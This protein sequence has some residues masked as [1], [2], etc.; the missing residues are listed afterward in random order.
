MT[1]RL[2][3]AFV[4]LGLTACTPFQV[5]DYLS[6][7]GHYVNN[8]DATTISLKIHAQTPQGARE[9]GE[10][11][12]RRRGWGYVQFLCLDWLWG[13]HESGWDRTAHNPFSGAHGIPQALPGK[14]MA[15]HGTDWRTN[16][17][18]QITWGLDYIA[19]RYGTPCGAKV[20]WEKRDLVG[21]G[22]Y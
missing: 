21:A 18:T 17:Y 1:R 11:L 12:S 8:I 10:E 2:I 7:R 4:L 6:D 20:A 16:G 14:K 9:V 3:V 5:Q 19:E 13:G 15:S 22:W